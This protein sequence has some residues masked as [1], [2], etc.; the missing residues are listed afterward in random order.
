MS[1]ILTI[2]IPTY[3]RC[4]SLRIMLPKL[5][6]AIS[7]WQ[8]E[9]EVI[10]SDNSSSDQTKNFLNEFKSKH[11]NLKVRFNDKNIGVSRNITQLFS[12]A[13]SKYFMFLG[14]DD[15]IYRKSLK[16]LMPILKSS[17]PPIAV[18][19]T[20]WPWIHKKS[21][22]GYVDF[23]DTVKYFYEIGN[24]WAGIIDREAALSTIRNN[25][26]KDEVEQTVWPQTIM[27]Y[28][29]MYQHRDRKVYLTSYEIG[30]RI[31][32]GYNLVNRDYYIKSLV[33]LIEAVRIIF[34]HTQEYSFVRQFLSLKNYGFRSHIKG[35]FIS[36]LV[37]P[38]K[39]DHEVINALK[40]IESLRAKFFIII[41]IL[42]QYPALVN[43]IGL[44]AYCLIKFTPPWK[45]FRYINKLRQNDRDKVNEMNMKSIRFDNWF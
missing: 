16:N 40:K 19:Q 33:G 2:G 12:M 22:V 1:T 25:D 6:E 24:A 20:Q 43:A 41:F 8:D 32:E 15:Q 5:F 14:D 36:S 4:V 3:N 17:N 27:A 39:Y 7:D 9:I 28:L 38:F 11:N 45:Y 13:Q 23:K 34:S 30:S 10:V 18:I 42:L 44:V 35:L 26:V 37:Y 31:G 21:K 29:A